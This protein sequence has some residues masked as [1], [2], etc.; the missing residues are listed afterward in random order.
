MK[1]YSSSVDKNPNKFELYMYKE[2]GIYSIQDL[3]NHRKD[4]P[5]S[6]VDL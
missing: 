6:R 3:L 2:S 1:S 5:W 4:N